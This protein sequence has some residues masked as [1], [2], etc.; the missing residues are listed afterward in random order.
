MH[1]VAAAMASSKTQKAGM[2]DLLPYHELLT[3]GKG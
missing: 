2:N 1:T 3:L